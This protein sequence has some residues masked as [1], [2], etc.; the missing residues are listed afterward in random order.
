MKLKLIEPLKDLFKDEVR[1]LGKALNISE[2]FIKR[3]PFPSPGLAI[4]IDGD[5][6]EEKIRLIQEIDHIFIQSIKE[7]GIYDEILQAFVFLTDLRSVGVLGDRR[8]YDIRSTLW[9]NILL[10]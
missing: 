9:N 8:T 4:R 10:E 5:I 2:D 1:E 3:H 7:F 6:T